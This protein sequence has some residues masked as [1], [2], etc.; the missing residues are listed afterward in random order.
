MRPVILVKY[1]QHPIKLQTQKREKKQIATI[2]KPQINQTKKGSSPYYIS[3]YRVFH[4]C[5]RGHKTKYVIYHHQSIIYILKKKKVRVALT[6]T[7]ETDN[8][9]SK[10]KAQVWQASQGHKRWTTSQKDGG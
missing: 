8:V 6:V 2:G 1:P 4:T 3:L 9:C 7:Q 5:K 10:T